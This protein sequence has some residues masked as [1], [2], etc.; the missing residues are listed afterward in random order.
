MHDIGRMIAGVTHV[1]TRERA[2][3]ASTG[4]LE[5]DSKHVCA[6]AMIAV[7]GCLI[8]WAMEA[9]ASPRVAIRAARASLCSTFCK[10]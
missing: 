6:L 9:E 1:L 8:S 5:S 10:A 3:F 2:S 4:S 7:S